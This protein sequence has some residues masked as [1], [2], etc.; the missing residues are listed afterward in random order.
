M[1][2]LA[3]AS[4]PDL[5]PVGVEP[6]TQPVSR[7]YVHSL[8]SLRTI[9]ALLVIFAHV[10]VPNATTRIAFFQN[11]GL[12]VDFFFV[13]SGFVIAMNYWEISGA[14][15]VWRY[16]RARFARIYPLHLLTL[17]LFLGLE[18]VKYIGASKL[19]VEATS[20]A[21]SKNSPGAFVLS[22]LLL[23][24]HGLTRTVT[25]N[26]PSWS[27]GAEATCYLLFAAILLTT[28][29]SARRVFL[30]LCSVMVA[31]ILYYVFPKLRITNF[32][33]IRGLLGFGIGCVWW[34]CLKRIVLLKRTGLSVEK[35]S[36]HWKWCTVN[37]LCL[38]LIATGAS[39]L[40]YWLNYPG[41]H[42]FA[43][44]VIGVCAVN[45]G[46]PLIGFLERI[47]HGWFGQVSYGVYLW[48]YFVIWMSSRVLQLVFKYSSVWID[49]SL[50]IQCPE[51][52]GN[53]SVICTIVVTLA[54]AHLSF[55]YFEDPWRRRLRL[56]PIRKPIA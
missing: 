25:F 39:A 10:V 7:T 4:A 24:A 2:E 3:A 28:A 55:K 56:A 17:F 41:I 8:D 52:I 6:K 14:R 26:V 9:A 27:I 12:A 33:V 18:L 30:I 23:N 15:P 44:G 13:L 22:L 49:G 19:S 43:L 45:P 37:G 40:R 1:I 50:A 47:G 16:L 29:N 11:T 35:P 42:L 32:G 5:K 48:H 34:V 51:W 20:P 46:N 36:A 31:G 54:V 21:F 38:V 53:A